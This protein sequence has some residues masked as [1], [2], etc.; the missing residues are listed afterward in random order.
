MARKTTAMKSRPAPEPE[1]DE[2]EDELEVEDEDEEL[3]ELDEDEE[4]ETPTRSKGKKAGSSR[5]DE[6]TFGA[7]HLS[8]HLSKVMGK[9]I[10]PR[11]LRV[12]LRKMA[13]SGQLNREI[14]Q[15]TRARYD[16]P[17][18]LED[19]EVKRIVKAV[20]TGA[21]EQGKK[22]ALDSLKARKAAGEIGKSK[23]GASAKTSKTKTKG[24]APKPPVDEEEDFEED[25]EDEDED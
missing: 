12:L 21:I 7:K 24:K 15:G 20:K 16:W 18:G 23:G 19:P 11:D 8:A 9:E 17:K 22:E 4:S 10:T 25:F 3:T 13:R 2:V 6:V 14:T 5:D 1:E